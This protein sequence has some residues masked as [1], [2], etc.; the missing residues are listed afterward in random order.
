MGEF[1][2]IEKNNEESSLYL[3]KVL[4][5]QKY[6]NRFFNIYKIKIH[7][8]KIFYSKSTLQIFVSFYTT[9][10]TIAVINKKLSKHSKILTLLHKFSFLKKT[11]K[12]G[13][14]YNKTIKKKKIG[15]IIS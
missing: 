13:K 10:Q 2:H 7:N 5:I 15:K 1:K 12:R 3:Y 4:Q 9:Q 6:L 8:C 11:K 14:L